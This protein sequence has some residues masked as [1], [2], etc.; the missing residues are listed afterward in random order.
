M[1]NEV[2][3]D[4]ICNVKDEATISF[5]SNT[6]Q[7]SKV[8]VDQTSPIFRFSGNHLFILEMKPFFGRSNNYQMKTMLHREERMCDSPIVISAI[9]TYGTEYKSGDYSFIVENLN[10][11]NDTDDKKVMVNLMQK[12]SKDT[13]IYLLSCSKP[14]N[15]HIIDK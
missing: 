9:Q 2:N 11:S 6:I 3:L 7:L 1:A 4:F 12:K 8:L 10:E 14:I 5:L 15:R 13:W